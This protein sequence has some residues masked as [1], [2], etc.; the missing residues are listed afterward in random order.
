MK[1]LLLALCTACLCATACYNDAPL[2]ERVEDLDTRLTTLE[3]TVR[4][5][6]GDLQ[7]LQRLVDALQQNKTILSVAEGEEDG[8]KTWTITFS[9]KSTLTVRSGS[10]GKDG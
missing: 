5:L 7:T 10:D 1:K 3:K 8:V 4:T 6:N 2:R 9:D